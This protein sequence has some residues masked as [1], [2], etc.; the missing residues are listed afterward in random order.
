MQ[1]FNPLSHLKI[2]TKFT[3]FLIVPLSVIL[4][5]SSINIHEK[6]NQFKSI[7]A[8]D[9][10][11]DLSLELAVIV[12]EL[13]KER[14]LSA[15]YLG[16]EKRL[17]KTSLEQQ[18]L[19]TDEK[20]K[21]FSKTLSHFNKTETNNELKKVFLPAIQQLEPLARVRNKIDNKNSEDFFAYYSQVNATIITMI[22][23][24]QVVSDDNLLS[25]QGHAYTSLLWLQ[26]YMG[27]ERGVL[28]GVFA[29]RRIKADLFIDLSAYVRNQQNSLRDFSIIGSAE[30]QHI[31]SEKSALPLN[32]EVIK[33][34]HVA[35]DQ[36]IRL[37]LLNQI[38]QVIGY[39]GLIHDFKNF[40][41][42]GDDFYVNRFKSNYSKMLKLL[43]KYRDL[44][45]SNSQQM[46]SL[47]VIEKTFNQ[48][49]Q[50]LET[51]KS[52]KKMGK[53]TQLIDQFIKVDDI[54]AANA[55]KQLRVNVSVKSVEV[56]WD[57]ATHRLELI[58]QVSDSVSND[59]KDRIGTI[60]R[61]SVL[62]LTAYVLITFFTLMLTALFAYFLLQRLAGE[63]LKI[64][65]DLNDMRTNGHFDRL[66]DVTGNDEITDVEKA[67]N[68]LI[69]ERNKSEASLRL[70]DVVF[71][72]STE[73]ILISDPDN[74]IVMVNP[75]FNRITGYS[76]QEV[77]GKTPAILQSGRQDK[78]FYETMWHQLLSKGHWEGEIWNK[79]KNGEI[80]LEWLIM[81]IIQKADGTI[82]NY[83]AMFMDI[84]K[85]KQYEE[86]L[87][88]HANYDNLTELPNRQM[89]TEALKQAI[90]NA[91]RLKTQITI[92][93]LN[94]DRFKFVNSSF[95]HLEGDKL[96]KT[97]AKRLV[98]SV[99]NSDSVARLGNDE[100][101]VLIQ[102]TADTYEIELIVKKLLQ[103]LS[104]PYAVANNNSANISVSIGIA[105][106]PEDGS[107]AE[108]LL[109][110]ADTAMYKA[111]EKGKNNFQF[112]TEAMNTKIALYSELEQEL[113]IAIQEEKLCLYYQPIYDVNKEKIVAAEALIRWPHET[114][115]LICPDEFIPLAEET[116]LIVPLGKW[117][118]RSAAEFSAEI[119]Q[120]LTLPV[121]VAINISGRQCFDDGKEILAL[122][123][124]IQTK[125]PSSNFID[126]EITESMLMSP[127]QNIISFMQQIRQ[128]GLGIH[129]DDFGTGYSS[130]S[131]LK[132]FPV[133][134]LKIDKTFI[135]NIIEDAEDGK[136]AQ[137]IIQLG[138]TLNL[139]TIAEGVETAEQLA[140]LKANDC[141]LI[142]GYYFSKPLPADEFYSLLESEGYF[143]VK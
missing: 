52:M 89:L 36:S 50:H 31:L 11:I 22:Q 24:M 46:D 61:G 74:K 122:I 106:Y 107:N 116:S 123:Q 15:G 8:A 101:V 33:M 84:T 132:R 126:L 133:T 68:E 108:T 1:P 87:W 13:Q 16:S 105:I 18:R 44:P 92:L 115:G 81:D 135:Q 70:S 78:T 43:Q 45:G 93:F 102:S 110:N 137:S 56:W 111:K 82:Q 65:T 140:F 40:V 28:N 58:K 30:Q 47:A 95:G 117:I 34:R 59:L 9:R 91:E 29:S 2:R 42:R 35:I 38:K 26:E 121:R 53:S 49:Y 120:N 20:L 125:T 97:V 14:G 21:Q 96:L 75:A 136:L 23:F 109:N 139:K 19:T 99:R 77:I 79:R 57:K 131:Y 41:I 39:T 104:D 113:R 142:Q 7:Q 66:L 138:H 55:F 4:F 63:I 67:F 51:V 90:Y 103:V 130:L 25:R 69:I 114:K 127:D 100:F 72:S 48:Y 124:D 83:V 88:K 10:F 37:D 60:K 71:R 94:L 129:L 98:S 80:Y 32:D 3:L 5:F 134:K 86:S 54:P 118:I 128:L 141:D 76:N 112:F 17:F 27:Q 6:Y 85:H 143:N 64:A 119:N 62:A 73:A 12:H